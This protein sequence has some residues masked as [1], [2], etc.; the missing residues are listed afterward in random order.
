MK[1]HIGTKIISM[2][3]VL[4]AVFLLN[5]LINRV[6]SEQSL[7]AV[8]QVSGIYLELQE[9]NTELVKA[10]DE[11]KLYGNMITMLNDK[12]TAS[13][14]AESV[15]V[16]IEKIE[17]V[18]EEMRTICEKEGNP[19]LLEILGEYE[20]A[21]QNLEDLTERIASAYLSGNL[22]AAI[23][24]NSGMYTAVTT[25][26]EKGNEFDSTLAREA[27]GLVGER[28]K[29][30]EQMSILTIIL[31][32]VYAAAV[33]L[34]II[35]VNHSI[36]KPAKLAS[37]QL[38]RIIQK[39]ENNEGDLTERIAAK[40]QDEVGELVKGVNSFI[41]QLQLIMQ[42]IQKE[43]LHMNELVNN[44]TGGIN[45]SN[46]NASNVSAT[47]EELSAS[48]EEVSATLAQI[49][50]GTE[51]ILKA[52]RAMS[53]RAENGAG[54]VREMKGRAE[55]VKNLAAGSK[56]STNRMLDSIRLLLKNA[57]ENSKSVDKINEL[58]G[59]ILDISSQTNLLA[60]NASI[61]AARAGDAGK[62][63]AVVA[64]EIRVLADNSRDT[65]N[66]IQ[67]IS[68]LVTNAV[69]ELA[70]NADN[71]LQFIDQTVL[72]DYDKFVDVANRYHDDADNMDDMLREFYER[73]Q[74][75]EATM[76]HMT[77]GIAGINTAVDESAQGV[78]MA[79][80]S[81]S[82][83]VEALSMIKSEADTNQ[84]ISAQ[85]QDEVRRFK[86]I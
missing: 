12:E 19:E 64:D 36:A 65:A 45:H 63:F 82:E 74:N 16:T 31:F 62:G 84:E 7:K 59:D 66:N 68:A 3:V 26:T 83:L 11:C 80:E 5:A 72:S 23:S 55:D 85:L 30:A 38:S 78:T 10:I 33:V 41:G 35:V 53:S 61:E 17:T 44:I 25:V 34:V 1:K 24:A 22:F 57:I 86:N 77:D 69:E 47:M 70:K 76:A 79:A 67:H 49:T 9:K 58:T 29:A 8:R 27:D 73:T 56:E 54:Y 71:M 13:T 75:L 28:T 48:M 50:E 81:T 18:F 15:P 20:T 43:S 51:E 60:L 14:I 2:I 21:A 52:S 46:E 40:T 32:L 42:K 4:V 6:A 37:R 39:I